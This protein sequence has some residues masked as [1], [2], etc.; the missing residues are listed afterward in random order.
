MLGDA[1]TLVYLA[2]GQGK[3]DAVRRAFADEPS[4]ATPASLVRGA[5]TIAILDLAAAAAL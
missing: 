1:R 2:T 3:A 5:A 4:P